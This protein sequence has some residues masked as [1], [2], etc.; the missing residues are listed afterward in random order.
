MRLKSAALFAVGFLFVSFWLHGGARCQSSLAPPLSLAPPPRSRANVSPPPL[1]ITLGGPGVLVPGKN[2]SPHA[3]TP[4]GPPPP[5]PKNV[6]PQ[7]AKA[8]VPPQTAP[9]K[10]SAGSAAAKTSSPPAT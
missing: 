2:I 9:P 6:G 7:T 10:V 3:K 8:A 4:K 1:T 5:P